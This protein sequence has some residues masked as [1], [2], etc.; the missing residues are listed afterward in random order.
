ME[1]RN[2]LV[3]KY[4]IFTFLF[5][6][7]LYNSV[8]FEKLDARKEA[9]TLQ[10]FDSEAYVSQFWYERLPA[11]MARSTPVANI[12]AGLNTDIF[13]TGQKFGRILG[14]ASTYFFLLHGEGRVLEITDEGI[15]LS[16]I[17]NQSKADILIATSFIFGNAIRDASGLIDVSDFPSSMEF[18]NISSE[19][20][21]LVTMELIPSFSN[22]VKPGDTLL[23]H[24]AAEVNKDEPEI[25]PLKIIPIEVR[26]RE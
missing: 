15:V 3:I 20:N 26:I 25:N 24:G 19:I 22:K 14:L 10:N 17:R 13:Q 11:A 21:K 4:I 16:I 9:Q 2:K 8:F 23:F 12:L 1:K 5:G 6:F 7:V 18:N